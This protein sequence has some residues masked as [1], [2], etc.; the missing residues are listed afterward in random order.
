MVTL[1]GRGITA[2]LAEG[3]LYC[4]VLWNAEIGKDS[5][6]IHLVSAMFLFSFLFFFFFF[7][8]FFFLLAVSSRL[9]VEARFILAVNKC[10]RRF[11]SFGTRLVFVYYSNPNPGGSVREESRARR[12]QR[13]IQALVTSDSR[14]TYQ[15]HVSLAASGSSWSVIRPKIML[16]LHTALRLDLFFFFL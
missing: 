5:A 12:V 15:S 4:K 3:L 2:K 16:C 1:F 14:L 9:D 8:F 7:F 6:K 10:K 13:E 11:F